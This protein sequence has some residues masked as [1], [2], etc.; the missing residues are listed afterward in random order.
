MKALEGRVAVVTGASTGI[1]RAVASEFARRGMSVV[2]ASQNADRL[3][4]A[5]EAISS[6]GAPV[7]AVPTDVEDRGAVDRLA[8]ATLERFGAVHVLVNNAGVYAPGYAWEISDTDW[9]WVIGVNLWGTIYGIKAFMPHLLA[10]D[11]AHVVNVASAGG[12]MTTPTHGPYTASKH[13]VVGLSKGLRADLAIKQARVGVTVVCPGGVATDITSQLETTGPGGR[14]REAIEL[15][16]EV[17][18]VWNAIDEVANS[19]IAADDV[20]PMVADAI[21]EERFWLLPNAECY[22]DV[23]DKEFADLKAER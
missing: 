8:E 10:Q 4:L 7:L 11:E 17:Q 3:A 1:G 20:G 15:P 5:E 12:L 2:I 22:F 19:G 13:A 21:L 23:F 6:I 14:P 9:E 16:A 18:G